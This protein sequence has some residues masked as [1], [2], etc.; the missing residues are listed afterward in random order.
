LFA[1]QL[2]LSLVAP[3]GDSHL[4]EFFTLIGRD[5]QAVDVEGPRRKDTHNLEQRS[6]TVLH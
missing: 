1:K 6:V 5:M 4:T 3:N 2:A